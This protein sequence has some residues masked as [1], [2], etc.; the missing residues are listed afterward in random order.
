LL[1]IFSSEPHFLFFD[2]FFINFSNADIALVIRAP[3]IKPRELVV[4]IIVVRSTVIANIV[5]CRGR[6]DSMQIDIS[7]ADI[8]AQTAAILIALLVV[9]LW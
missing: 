6:V 8:K 9:L 5:S 3:E 4:I 2:Y 7:M 1:V